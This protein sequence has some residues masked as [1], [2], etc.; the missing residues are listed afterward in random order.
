MS[1]PWIVADRWG[2]QVQIE[3]A[4]NGRDVCTMTDTRQTPPTV[5]VYTWPA[6]RMSPGAYLREIGHGITDDGDLALWNAGE[7][8]DDVPEPVP[9]S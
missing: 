5:N 9:P 6:G 4:V 3:I 8:P 2:R 1:M 7:A